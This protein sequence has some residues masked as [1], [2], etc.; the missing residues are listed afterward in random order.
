MAHWFHRNPLKATAVQN[1]DFKSASQTGTPQKICLEARQAR[2]DLLNAISDPGRDILSIESNQEK[3]FGL[4]HG[5]IISLDGG[6]SGSTDSSK[7]RH[8]I[9]FRWTHTLKG[10]T[11]QEQY[12]C[13]FELLNMAFN[14]GLWYTKHASKC[15]GKDD[16]SME[17][18]KEIHSSLKK[19]TGVFMYIK[20]Q[21][22]RLLQPAEDGS[23]LDSRV[24]EAYL[25]QSQ[26]E[27]QEVTIA[28][29]IELKHSPNLV[30]GLCSETSKMFKLAEENLKSL[31]PK[32]VG[33]WQK[34][35][36]LK[37][38][39]YRS[40]TFSYFGEHLLAQDKCGEAIRCLRE[41]VKYFEQAGSLCK[42]Y[43]TAKGPGTTA[44]PETQLFFRKIGQVVKSTLQKCE[45][46][47]GFIYHQKVPEAIPDIDVKASYGLVTADEFK[48]PSPNPLW[49]PDSYKCFNVA[50]NVSSSGTKPEPAKNSEAAK[51]AEGDLPPVKEESI[52]SSQKDPTNRSGCTIS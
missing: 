19:A 51:K 39:F 31:E 16:P 33:K 14:I 4:L 44:R 42:E 25:N 13:V 12:D 46:E 18:A 1:F 35:L 24:L 23:D 3:Y 11:P 26:A 20:A 21:V 15:A 38:D 48:L 50:A 37:S 10:Q 36:A 9:R 28:R 27:A 41:S 2:M 45:R 5:F 43:S 34:Y 8:G 30:A 17:E 47:N 7:M 6:E 49:T 29:A 22:T 40:A 52:P 32:E